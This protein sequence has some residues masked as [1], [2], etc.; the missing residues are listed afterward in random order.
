M[1]ITND[2]LDSLSAK[3]SQSGKSY[4]Q[5]FSSGGESKTKLGDVTSELNDVQPVPATWR[6]TFRHKG[7]E[8]LSDLGLRASTAAHWVR[9]NSVSGGRRIGTAVRANPRRSAMIG[10]GVLLAVGAFFGR[11]ALKSV[12]SSLV[13]RYRAI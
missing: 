5:V 7:S 8:A 10:T 4:E 11:H 9:D 12:A 2:S 13:S 6:D 1:T 3:G